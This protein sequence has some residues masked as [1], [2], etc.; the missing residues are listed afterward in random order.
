MALV[1][2]LGTLDFLSQDFW[3]I[4]IYISHN[5]I[6]NIPLV[7]ILNY[8]LRRLLPLYI[9]WLSVLY[10]VDLM[11]FL[12]S[13][14]SQLVRLYPRNKPYCLSFLIDSYF[15][16]LFYYGNPLFSWCHPPNLCI[17][18]QCVLEHQILWPR[19]SIRSLP[20]FFGVILHPVLSIS[21]FN[22]SQCQPYSLSILLQSYFHSLH[23][24]C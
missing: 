5:S 19:F 24:H 9:L 21:F 7:A 17:S 23:W 8:T 22:G 12:V 11:I 1:K 14:S 15:W 2:I 18:T 13:L 16:R 4:Y 6:L 3:Y 20:D 10:H